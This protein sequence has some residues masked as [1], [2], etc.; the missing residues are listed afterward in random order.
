MAFIC[1][2]IWDNPSH[3]LSYFSRWLK[4]PT[5][6]YSMSCHECVMPFFNAKLYPNLMPAMR[7]PWATLRS[8][9]HVPEICLPAPRQ[10]PDI[11]QRAGVVDF[12]QDITRIP[13]AI[14]G[15]WTFQLGGLRVF[16]SWQNQI[17]W[18]YP[19]GGIHHYSTNPFGCANVGRSWS[20]N[21]LSSP[22]PSTAP[23]LF[24]VMMVMEILLEFKVCPSPLL[25]FSDISGP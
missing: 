15:E 21:K 11:C 1:H 25:F 22:I 23:L 7:S 12:F 13:I 2:N 3:W 17:P 20:S 24:W 5:R 9:Q 18:K 6:F 19:L 4:P 14:N 10:V 8:K 16:C